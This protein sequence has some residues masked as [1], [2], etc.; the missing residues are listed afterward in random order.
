MQLCKE[1][2]QFSSTLFNKNT[3]LNTTIDNTTL[4]I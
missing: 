1:V 4:E 3:I 2:T